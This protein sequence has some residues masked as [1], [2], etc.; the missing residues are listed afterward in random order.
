MTR[1]NRRIR[2]TDVELTPG[3]P[4]TT[5]AALGAPISTGVEPFDNGP[6]ATRVSYLDEPI[7]V[8]SPT[9]GPVTMTVGW[10]ADAEAKVVVEP[11]EQSGPGPT[12]PGADQDEPQPW[13][14]WRPLR[15]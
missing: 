3:H 12:H 11:A 2:S 13:Q 7:T 4:V 9:P 15:T 14:L 10:L 5:E 1:H 8:H 6:V